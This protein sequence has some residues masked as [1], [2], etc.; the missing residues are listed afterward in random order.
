MKK[1]NEIKM[2][3]KCSSFGLYKK[4]EKRT[5]YHL[6]FQKRNR[7]RITT[8]KHERKQIINKPN[9]AFEFF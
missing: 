3:I 1:K 4:N 5:H 8:N 2:L 6:R 7:F 9:L